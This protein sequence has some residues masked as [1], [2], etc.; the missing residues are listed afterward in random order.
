MGATEA[1]AELLSNPANK[2]TTEC[3]NTDGN[4]SWKDVCGSLWT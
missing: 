2:S 3:S 1:E 4:W